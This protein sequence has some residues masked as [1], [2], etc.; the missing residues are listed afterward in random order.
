MKTREK[1]IK[2]VEEMHKRIKENFMKS[3]FLCPVAFLITYDDKI[4][5]LGCDGFSRP[6]HKEAFCKA[7]KDQA[8]EAKAVGVIFA[9]ESWVVSMNDKNREKIR[10]AYKK[11]KGDLG[12]CPER[13]E[14]IMVNEE[15]LD[16]IVQTHYPIIRKG[17]K[18]SL[19]EPRITFTDADKVKATFE[20]RFTNLLNMPNIDEMLKVGG[21]K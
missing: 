4:A 8:L 21:R 20:G 2:F 7:I 19:G 18:V 6:E 1:H 9:S 10:K 17:K 11:S 15:Y 14:V 13:K 16:G 5:V 3:G 12:K